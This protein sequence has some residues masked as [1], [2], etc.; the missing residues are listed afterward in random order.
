M[1]RLRELPPGPVL[2][3][4]YTWWAKFRGYLATTRIGVP[5][6]PEPW[7]HA[8]TMFCGV[9]GA[10]NSLQISPNGLCI[11]F[12]LNTLPS[13]IICIRNVPFKYFTYNVLFVSIVSWKFLPKKRCHFS[14]RII[15]VVSS[16][17]C[18]Q[19]AKTDGFVREISWPESCWLNDA[20]AKFMHAWSHE[21]C[22]NQKITSPFKQKPSIVTVHYRFQWRSVRVN[23]LFRKFQMNHLAEEKRGKLSK[24]GMRPCV[25]NCTQGTISPQ[26]IN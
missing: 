8:G 20:L 5:R 25:K 26:L 15:G 11:Y 18:H 23:P 21:L 6:V 17:P 14:L 7:E 9:T 13:S 3:A 16:R 12:S 1:D 22:R 2:T 19:S 24:A 4:N 10:R